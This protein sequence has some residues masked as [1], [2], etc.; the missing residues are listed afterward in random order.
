[1]IESASIVIEYFTQKA[2]EKKSKRNLTLKASN[3]DTPEA[4]V[5]TMYFDMM[6]EKNAQETKEVCEQTHQKMLA[7]EART[8]VDWATLTKQQAPT[9]PKYYMASPAPITA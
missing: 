2:L 4:S 5:K 8:S 1:M 9:V 3:E 6:K 7:Q